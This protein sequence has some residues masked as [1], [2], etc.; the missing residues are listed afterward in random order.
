MHVKRFLHK[1]VNKSIHKTKLKNLLIFVETVISTKALKLT[2]LGRALKGNAQERSSIRRMDRF[3]ANDFFQSE[4]VIFYKCM[5]KLLIGSKKN[6]IIIVDWTKLPN[7]NHYA[8]RASLA[9]KGRS[10]TLY[11]EVHAKKFEGNRKVHKEF[12]NQLKDLLLAE[13]CPIIVTDAGFKNPWFKAV[14]GLGW[15][16]IGRVRGRMHYSDGDDFQEVKGLFNKAT[17]IPKYLGKKTLTKNN[18][19]ITS[20]YI[21]KA[22]LKGRKKLNKNGKVSKDKDSKNHSRSYREPWLLVSSLDGKQFAKKVIDIYKTRMGIEEAFR[23]LK[24]PQYGFSFNEN[25]TIRSER[26]IVWLL[27]A[28]LA[29]LCAWIAGFNAEEERLHKQ[30]QANSIKHRRVLSYFYLGCQVIRKKIDIPIKISEKMF[31]LEGLSHG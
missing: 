7:T 17:T 11:E 16:Y 8:L 27:L 13:C 3:L 23:D 2:H 24:S 1:L 4:Y 18:K 31:N 9:A 28:A 30:F 15:D 26:L 25:K 10:L 19:F 22:K 29:S 21:F 14:V 20:F 12:L 5:A 6:P